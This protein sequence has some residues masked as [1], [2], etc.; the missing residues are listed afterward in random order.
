MMTASQFSVV[1]GI[2]GG[3]FTL[4][5][6]VVG[7]IAR[8]AWGW[9]KVKSSIEGVREDLANLITDKNAVHSEMR[10]RI[11]WLERNVGTSR[12]RNRREG[13]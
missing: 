11:L 1:I 12:Q 8:A 10:E 7:L 6:G 5:C 2:L 13:T 4:L 3:I 9:A